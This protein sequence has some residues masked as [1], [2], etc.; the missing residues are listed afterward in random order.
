MIPLH[1]TLQTE[2]KFRP[3]LSWQSCV[4]G[5]VLIPNNWMSMTI[6]DTVTAALDI[7]R[8]DKT[9]SLKSKS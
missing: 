7:L 5:G 2:E 4:C 1:N 6:S 3:V 9:L 8:E